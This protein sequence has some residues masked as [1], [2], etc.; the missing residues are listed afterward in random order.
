MRQAG[1]YGRC[2]PPPNRGFKKES[3]SS[4]CS[5]TSLPLSLLRAPSRPTGLSGEQPHGAVSGVGDPREC[6]AFLRVHPLGTLGVLGAQTRSGEVYS[7]DS[8]DATTETPNRA[9][10]IGRISPN[11]WGPRR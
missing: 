7:L 3:V 1:I 11:R 10:T 4:G 6:P 9:N 2:T 5:S 8:V